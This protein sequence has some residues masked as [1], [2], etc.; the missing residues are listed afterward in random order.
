MLDNALEDNDTV[1]NLFIGWYNIE[2]TDTNGCLQYDSVCVDLTVKIGIPRLL[3][4]LDTILEEL[5][6]EEV[7]VAEEMEENSPDFYDEIKKRF[8]N[9][10]ISAV[11]HNKLESMLPKTKGIVRT[12]ETIAWANSIL[13]AVCVFAP[14]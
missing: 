11:P 9:V 8:K 12:G 2:I 7:I 1:Y 5:F 10:K 3:D 13:K 6:L 14:E 4:V